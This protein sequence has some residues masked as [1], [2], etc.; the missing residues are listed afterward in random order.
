MIGFI[1]VLIILFAVL[2]H[3]IIKLY[4]DALSESMISSTPR[5]LRTVWGINKNK[6]L[7]PHGNF[8]S[9]QRW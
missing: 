2:L 7:Y 9:W 4:N 8:L 5:Q 1:I 6:Q 3:A